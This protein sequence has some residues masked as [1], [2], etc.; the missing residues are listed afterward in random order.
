MLMS[1]Q[2]FR[3]IQEL[4]ARQARPW[5]SVLDAG[6]GAHSLT[7]LAGVA[8]CSG[9]TAVTAA[10]D[11]EA[12][13]REAAPSVRGQDRF[14]LGNWR[15][16]QFL[17]GERFDIVLADY[18]LGALDAYDPYGQDRLFPRLR[19]HVGGRLYVVGLE[20]SPPRASQPWGRVLLEVERLRDACIRLAGQRAYREYPS[21]WVQRN[22]KRAGYRIHAERVFPIRYGR[23]YVE[24]QLGVGES[25]LD[26]IREVDAKLAREL[27]AALQRLREGARRVEE[28]DGRATFGQDYLIAATVEPDPAR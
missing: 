14:A 8:G 28:R 20:P 21:A 5:G 15:D 4:E 1:D 26:L 16:P 17:K 27:E 13:L 25:K 3:A 9:W 19:P 11:M 12:T 7:W 6:S 18:L 22:L 10:P 24:S 23:S 2:I